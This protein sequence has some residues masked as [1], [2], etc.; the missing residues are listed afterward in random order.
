MEKIWNIRK[1]SV[2]AL[3][4]IVFIMSLLIGGLF[5][6]I[7]VNATEA[8]YQDTVIVPEGFQYPERIH[9]ANRD[10]YCGIKEKGSVTVS[11]EDGIGAIYIEFDR[12][13]QSWTLTDLES[14]TSI[15]CGENAF[16]HEFVDVESVFG[17]LPTTLAMCFEEGTVIAD[18][19]VFSGGELPAWVQKW[20]PPCEEAD[21]LLISSHSDDEQ[22]FFSGILPYY[23][24]ER[25]LQVQVAYVVQHFEANNVK[26]HQRPHEQLDGLWTVGVRNYPV[27]SVFP[28]LYA[29]SKERETAFAQAA[30]VY[31]NVGIT[32]DD[33]VG[34]ITE[35]LRRFKPLVVVSHDLDGEYGHGTHVLCASALTEAI[36]YAG[37]EGKYPESAARY[38]TWR[39]EKTYLHLYEE[40]PIVMDFDIP[41]ESF[42]GKTAFE[43]SQD[44]FACHK[45]QHWTWF[46]KWIYG[47]AEKPVTKATDIKKYS[48]CLYGLYDTQVGPDAAGGDFF[49]NIET[50]EERALAKAEAEA[51]RKAKEEAE[52]ARKAKEEA[53]GAR[54]AKEE[55][56]ALKAQAEAEEAAGKA[57]EEAAAIA[58]AEELA[59]AETERRNTMLVVSVILCAVVMLVGVMV[60]YG[61]RSKT[62]SSGSKHG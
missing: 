59:K 10:T 18:I 62:K 57:E 16:L 15:V 12:I 30:A 41:L 8:E 17:G 3:G 39:V 5:S 43:V 1:H 33:F 52:A 58:Q 34:Y 55:A 61:R 50:Y 28:D 24:G 4:K 46:Y 60:L 27:M 53:E 56:E 26:N 13:P 11:R 23:A 29:E 42:G 51:A 37:D 32:Y 2:A 47:T 7:T 38:G 54:K 9:D 35:C 49:E 20:Q 31:E 14:G 45:S 25:G 44:G 48:P 21:L 6:P 40:N 36:E 19:Y 22:L